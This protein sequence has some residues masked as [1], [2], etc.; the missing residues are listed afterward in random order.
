VAIVIVVILDAGVA[1]RRL[2]LM[3]V[4]GIFVVGNI[5]R[6]RVEILLF[7]GVVVLVA[8]VVRRHGGRVKAQL[9][10]QGK[11]ERSEGLLFEGIGFDV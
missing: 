1:L 5:G 4:V 6:L 9:A 7:L 11:S 8:V 2:R 10:L 3:D